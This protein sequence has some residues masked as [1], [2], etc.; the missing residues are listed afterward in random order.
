MPTLALSRPQVIRSYLDESYAPS[1]PVLC[2]RWEADG[3]E[4]RLWELP[5]GMSVLGPAPRLLGFTVHRTK[6]G[7]HAARLIW[8]RTC[9]SWDALSSADLLTS[10]LSPLLAAVGIDLWYL[11]EDARAGNGKGPF[12]A[13]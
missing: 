3:Q 7:H 10:C 11:L 5:E 9:L 8:D 13:A 1:V 4:E 6:A 2:L 12:R